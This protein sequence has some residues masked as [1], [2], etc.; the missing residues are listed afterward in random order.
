[1]DKAKQILKALKEAQNY[2][3][4]D[5]EKE[6]VINDILRPSFSQSVVS[7]GSVSEGEFSGSTYVPKRDEVRLRTQ[8]QRV[9]DWWTSN[10]GKWKTDFQCSEELGIP[11]ASAQARRR[12]LKKD[13]FGSFNFDSRAKGG[14]HY[15]MFLGG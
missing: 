7:K 10:A 5:E 12:D 1:M 4:T 6:M 8:L 9:L 15:H 2:Y 13:E 14:T 11:Q 3:L